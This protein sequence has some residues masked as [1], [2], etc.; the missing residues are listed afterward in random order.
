MARPPVVTSPEIHAADRS[1]RGPERVSAI[2]EL[3]VVVS[4]LHRRGGLGPF[5]AAMRHRSY[6]EHFSIRSHNSSAA[7]ENPYRAAYGMSVA[8]ASRPGGDRAADQRS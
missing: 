5:E 4:A 2:G 8:R 1:F 6:T 3:L 7:A